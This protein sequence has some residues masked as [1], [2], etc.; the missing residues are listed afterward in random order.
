MKIAVSKVFLKWQKANKSNK[1]L[2]GVIDKFLVQ[3]HNASDIANV[4]PQPKA[5]GKNLRKVTGTV[6]EFTLNKSYRIYS[7]CVQLASGELCFYLSVVGVKGNTNQNDDIL[8]ALTMFDNIANE[9]WITWEP[10]AEQLQAYSVTNVHDTIV[11]VQNEADVVPAAAQKS[12]KPKGKKLDENGL[13]VKERKTL[14]RQQQKAEQQ[15]RAQ[16]QRNAKLKKVPETNS[17]PDTTDAAVTHVAEE[18]LAHAPKQSEKN[19]S[20]EQKKA[21]KIKD[22]VIAALHKAEQ[23]DQ[24]LADMLAAGCDEVTKSKIKEVQQEIQAVRK[25]YDNAIKAVLAAEKATSDAGRG[26]LMLLAKSAKGSVQRHISRAWSAYV[27]IQNMIEEDKL[28]N[29]NTDAQSVHTDAPAE[30]LHNNSA[31]APVKKLQNNPEEVLAEK[32]HNN[33]TEA[34]VDKLH[35]SHADAPVEKLQNNPEEVLAE[36]LHNNPAEATADKLHNNPADASVP[37]IDVFD[38]NG[39]D[40]DTINDNIVEEDTHLING[41]QGVSTTTLN[42]A[43]INKSNPIID[44]PDFQHVTDIQ[45]ELDVIEHDI[46][47]KQSQIAIAKQIIAIEESNIALEELAKQKLRL[48]RMKQMRSLQK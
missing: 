36:K 17:T 23:L 12:K 32:L 19:M 13:T 43:P 37:S 16:Q 45:Y 39:S 46:K 1:P 6:D 18:I 33:P 42:G 48:L 38:D 26:R 8:T 9:A 4:T 5:A 10:S 41:T 3:I 14:R 24:A 27:A 15:Q 44:E 28:M 25:C 30:K 21:Q 40:N 31:E 47:I 29:P 2:M 11:P 34:P 35:N 22:T 7:R 20:K